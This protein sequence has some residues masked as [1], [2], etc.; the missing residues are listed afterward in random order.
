MVELKMKLTVMRARTHQ[1]S[2]V[3][4]D[5]EENCNNDPEIE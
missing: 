1:D 2:K 3:S 4:N 5:E